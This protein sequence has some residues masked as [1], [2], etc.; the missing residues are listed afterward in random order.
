MN[1]SR[2]E[3]DSYAIQSYTR[4]AEAWKSGAFKD[5]VIPVEVKDRKGNV[6][7]IAED[8]EFKNV[9]FDK[10]PGLRPVFT[11]D[12]TVTAANASTMNDGASALVLV[13]KEKA[14]E[15]G[16]Q[17]IAKIRG[18]ADAAQDPLWFTTAPALAIPKA[19][20]NAG[21]EE[22]DVD[23]YEINEAFSAVALANQKQLNLD[24]DKLNV[25]G[26]A[27]SLGHPLGASGARIISTLCSVLGQKSGKIGVAGICNGGGGASAIVI[28]K[29]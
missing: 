11:K 7:L 6:T 17:P 5:E 1:I 9:N 14:Q 18:F 2:E 10:I 24:A 27:V 22:N 28:E 13:S 25:Y 16:L 4:A 3:Q 21:I 19:I 12:G 20:K 15:L 26:G 29:L 23:F 8:E